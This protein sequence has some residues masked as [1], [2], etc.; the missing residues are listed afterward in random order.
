LDALVGGRLPTSAIERPAEK[1]SKIREVS[2]QSR[3]IF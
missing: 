1:G 3:T 2:W